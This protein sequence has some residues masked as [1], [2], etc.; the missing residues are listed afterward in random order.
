MVWLLGLKRC[1]MEAQDP[2]AGKALRGNFGGLPSTEKQIV[3][4][5]CNVAWNYAS[6]SKFATE[7][8]VV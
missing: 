2:H 5:G 6:S 7:V 4:D 8:R 1:M 3:I